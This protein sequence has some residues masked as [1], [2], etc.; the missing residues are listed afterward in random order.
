VEQKATRDN[1]IMEILKFVEKKSW[2]PR[3]KVIECRSIFELLVLTIISQITNWRNVR[4][5]FNRLKQLGGISPEV[6]KEAELKAIEE[7]LKPAGLYRVKAK[8]I[9]ELAVIFHK[10][11]L[12]RKLREINDMVKAREV[13]LSLPG[14]GFKTADIILVFCLGFDILPIDTHI[15][16]IAIRTGIANSKDSYDE[17]RLKLESHIPL[18]LRG[19]A[20]LA[21]IEF[22]RRICGSR[23]PRC[24]SC[25][26]KSIC[27]SSK[28]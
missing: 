13:L 25:P 27:P 8:R 19:W 6:I 18:G 9:K 3:S 12:E 28:V 21:L 20:H 15:R 26:V 1:I 7:A 24:S 4:T 23:K 11:D 22:G 16:R 14:I 17:I 5:V 2:V 10:Q